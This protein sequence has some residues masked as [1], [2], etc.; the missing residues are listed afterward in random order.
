ML[1]GGGSVPHYYTSSKQKNRRFL[2]LQPRSSRLQERGKE[3]L[4]KLLN[5]LFHMVRVLTK[6][7]LNLEEHCRQRDGERKGLVSRKFFLSSLKQLG[8]PF[9]NKELQDVVQHYSRP[10]SDQVDYLSFLKDARIYKKASLLSAEEEEEE[11]GAQS[12]GDFSSVLIAVKRMLLDAARSLSKHPDDIYRMFARWD[13]QGTGT[14]TATQFLRVLARLHVELSDQDQDSLVELLDTNA[15]GRID[16]DGLLIFCFGSTEHDLQSP[17]GMVI[18]T[19]PAAFD[20]AAGETLSA[21]STEG[22]NSLELK[23]TNSL[24]IGRRPHTASLSRPYN[25]NSSPH[26]VSAGYVVASS[27]SDWLPIAEGGA[28]GAAPRRYG[29]IRPLTASGRVLAHDFHQARHSGRRIGADGDEL[30]LMDLPDDVIH[31]EENY[32]P[33]DGVE[34][35][36]RSQSDFADEEFKEK[37]VARYDGSAPPSSSSHQYLQQYLPAS[38]PHFAAFEHTVTGSIQT[39]KNDE[40]FAE[41]SSPTDH[42]VLLATQ[43][44]ATLRDIILAR[45]RRGRGLQEIFQHFDRDGKRF[46]D[47]NDFIQATADLRIETSERVANIAIAQMAVD[48]I[49]RVSFGEFKVF[50][51]DADNKLLELNVQEQLASLFE[52]Q[53]REYQSWMCEVFW[54][55]DENASE[56]R[57]SAKSDKGQS[58]GFVSKSTFIGTLRKIGLVLTSAEVARLV[59]RFDI[60]GTDQ[61]SATRFVRMV[62]L[63]PAWKHAEAVLH[64]QDQAMQ[65]GQTLRRGAEHQVPHLSEELIS[66][67]EYLGICV[68]SE[69]N[70]IWIASDALKAPL[71]VNWTAQKDSHGRTFF[72]NRLTGQSRWEHP[73]DP[74]FRKLR[75][76]YRQ[77]A[78]ENEAISP[79][80]GFRMQSTRMPTNGEDSG[81]F[82]KQPGWQASFAGPRPSINAFAPQITG[83]AVESDQTSPAEAGRH[84]P[85]SAALTGATSILQQYGVTDPTKQ[86]RHRPISAPFAAKDAMMNKVPSLSTAPPTSAVLTATRALTD[87]IYSSGYYK[88]QP[89][90]PLRAS[91]GPS[92]TPAPFSAYATASSNPAAA[93]SKPRAT[94]ATKRT[95]VASRS[96]VDRALSIGRSSR[97]LLKVPDSAAAAAGMFVENRAGRNSKLTEMLEGNIIEKLDIA[98]GAKK[99]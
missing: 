95:G 36:A 1:E 85:H 27:A 2:E 44:L 86:G 5:G 19:Q 62:Q 39:E 65:E 55:D 12:L 70:M 8:L 68:L 66:M 67:C 31:G 37:E 52:Q 79:A 49:D 64:Y 90:V 71:P 42:L 10:D 16:F 32:L 23:S 46:F 56:S 81:Y 73:L 99:R 47:T 29:R 6:K 45:Y 75:D 76:K 13:T 74:H 87:A 96:A 98:M 60:H 24:G 43:T 33:N 58:Q 72:Y 17:H 22:N 21:V 61:C 15:M 88:S 80:R 4:S 69:Q 38:P 92:G 83:H 25:S 94:S 9:N 35:A 78:N 28:D 84:R 20:D 41:D 77:S 53:G 93:S 89:P 34:D 82:Q 57:V 48:G 59:D 40:V 54:S 14:V 3:A 63:S 97:D 11:R 91:A 7:G 51:L 50:V 30:L 18:G 26:G